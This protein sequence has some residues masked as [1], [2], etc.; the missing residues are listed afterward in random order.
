MNMKRSLVTAAFSMV[1]CAAVAATAQDVKP[2]PALPAAPADVSRDPN[3]VVV[4]VSLYRIRG[5]ISGETSLTDSIAEGVDGGKSL[6]KKSPFSFFTRAK[7]TIAG[8]KFQADQNGWKWDGKHDE[9]PSGSRVEQ[10]AAPQLVV[11]LPNNFGFLVDSGVPLQYFRKRPDGLFE[12]GQVSQATGL[13]MTAHVEKGAAGRILLRDFS[14]ETRFVEKRKPIEGV[15]LD[16][17]EPVI[18]AREAKMTVTVKLNQDYGIMLS[19]E[20]MG[21]LLLRLRL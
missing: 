9:P 17:G 15:T 4:R 3:A 18:I 14:L 21:S 19:S 7:L 13:K 20:G 5:D 16:V 12:L 10:I 11:V 2:Q 8:V 6:V 1:L